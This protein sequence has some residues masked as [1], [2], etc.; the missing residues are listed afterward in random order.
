MTVNPYADQEAL[1]AY[2]R[3]QLAQDVLEDGYPEPG[4]MPWTNNIL[5]PYIVIDFGSPVA[6]TQGRSVAGEE[7][8]PTSQRVVLSAVASSGKVAR[9]IAGKIAEVGTGYSV[10][11]NTGPLRLVGGGQFS[12]VVE[13]KPT[14][15]VSEVYFL[16]WANLTDA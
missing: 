7:K 4:D 6:T 13:S 16:Y 2:F 15:Y 1:A 3:T 12:Q 9:E 5:V 14:V 8:Q 11:S 10:S